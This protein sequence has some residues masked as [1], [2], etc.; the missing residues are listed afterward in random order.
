MARLGIDFG[1]SNT[2]AGIMAD[3]RPVTLPL[4]DGA[5]T[6]PT[7][8][9][10][11]F[12]DQKF[13]YGEAA[14]RAMMEGQDGRF[15]R[16]LKSIL[17]TPLAQEKR[18]FLNERLTLIEII[19]QFLA[20][21]RTRSEQLTGQSF[22]VAMSG[23]PV[24][25]HSES[26]E[27]D[28][29][30][31]V[32][33]RQAYQLAGFRD[34]EFLP[35]PEAAAL[36]VAGD[37]RM[38]IVDIGGG[39]SDFTL[40]ERKGGETQ[41]IASRGLRLGGTDFD[42]SLS[43]G[44]VMPLLGHG[45]EIGAEFGDKV[46]S[47]PRALFNDLASWEKIAFVYDPAT[48]REVKRWVRLAKKPELFERLAE[49]LDM[50]LGHDIAYAVEAGKIAANDSERGDIRLDVIE[51]GLHVDLWNL[52]MQTELAEAANRIGDMAL[53]T[54]RD[55]D[56][57]PDQVDMVVFVGGSSLLSGVRQALASRIPEARQ[58]TAEVFTAVVH[59]LAIAAQ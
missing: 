21:I 47:A 25:F 18:R 36:A 58:E 52:Q 37:G 35:E 29:Q 22:D 54:L 50:H 5:Q 42:R 1:T 32:D 17:G 59:G 19:G 8:V 3:G 6:L 45:A 16:G 2:G 55:A 10:V 53:A 15:M 26:R 49:V 41:V 20:E 43:L 12:A 4:E 13:I 46:H 48:L 34:V 30:A 31:E 51:R 57:A 24:M 39:T 27:K 14:A 56:C 9:F 11:D 28:A 38:L 33:L 44:H 7:A 23:R 40:C